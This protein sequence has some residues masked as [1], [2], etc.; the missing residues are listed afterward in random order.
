MSAVR[1]TD[2]GHDRGGHAMSA[3]DTA[4]VIA[5]R[6]VNSILHQRRMLIFAV[7]FGV[8]IPLLAGAG[9]VGVA[10]RLSSAI[11]LGTVGHL[12][13]SLHGSPAASMT[14]YR[15]SVKAR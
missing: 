11:G 10:V 8:I 9:F 5:W 3:V 2:N 12:H 15:A 1:A 4:W 14:H 6:E 13:A 7:G